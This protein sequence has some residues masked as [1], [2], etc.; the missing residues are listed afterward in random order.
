MIPMQMGNKDLI[1]SIPLNIEGFKPILGSFPAINQKHI[2]K[3][4]EGL[5]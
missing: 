2:L 5:G 3:M 1:D 4:S